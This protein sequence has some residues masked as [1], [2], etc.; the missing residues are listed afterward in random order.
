MTLM[1]D[2]I[3][4]IPQAVARLL[5]DPAPVQAAA[6]A[7]RTRDPALIATVARGSS[8]HAC[9]YLK[10]AAELTL[11][12]PVAS[13]G[14][15]VAS[16]YK[17]P[18]R[19]GT[20]LTLAVS[21]SGQSPDIL[22]TVAAARAAG[23]LTVGVTNDAASPLAA[24][25]D[26]P[27]AL[28]AGPERSVA[29]T[30]TF[31]TSAVAGLWLIA[32]W[33]DD[34]ALRAAIHDLPGHLDAA[35]RCD[36]SALGA[37]LQVAPTAYVLGR[38]PAYAIACEA[39]LKFKEVAGIHAEAYSSAEVLHGPVAIV[40]DGFPVLALAAADAAEPGLVATCT[41]MAGQGARVFATAAAPGLTALPRIATGHPLTDPLALITSFYA[42]VEVLAR[43][44]GHDPDRPRGL[45][46]VTRTV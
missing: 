25:V 26:H 33:A 34:A 17:A 42:M 36:W 16:V 27:L 40:G 8:D 24:A 5:A 38:G 28:Q 4:E 43:A 15:S 22:A 41:T 30:K 31:V 9:A 6:R 3:A 12:L 14:P 23:A 18:L 20:S 37:A 32:E 44:R 19:L 1:A 13:I 46:K 21:Q 45:N 10:Y 7:A 2:E 35:C 29:A 11:G 39:A